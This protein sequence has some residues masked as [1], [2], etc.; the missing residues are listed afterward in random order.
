M[1]GA[2]AVFLD[3]QHPRLRARRRAARPARS[4]I[5]AADWPIACADSLPSG[6]ISCCSRALSRPSSSTAPAL[7]AQR[8]SGRRSRRRGPRCSPTSSWWRCRRSSSARSSRPPSRGR[9]SRRRWWR[10]CRRRR[11]RPACRSRRRRARWP[12]SRWPR[13]G[14]LAHQLGRRLLGDRRRQHLH[15]V[16]R[17]AD[18]VELLVDELDQRAQ[19]LQPLGDGATITALRPFSALMILLAGVAAGLVDGVIAAD[20]ADRPRD[21]DDAARRVLGDHA[22]GAARL[23]VAQQP[24][25]LAVVLADLVVD[26][27]D[28]GVGDRQLGKRAV[29]SRLDDRPAGAATR[30]SMRAWS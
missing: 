16:A 1:L 10:R 28:A 20:H 4:A 17:R 14:R 9:R 23:Q 27:A 2:D 3:Q 26:V 18:S 22:D 13:P 11:R 30:S 21:L 19:V 29:A 7:A 25:R 6:H 15:Q 24:E 8:C 12:A 5:A